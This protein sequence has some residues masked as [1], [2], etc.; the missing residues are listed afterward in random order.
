[1]VPELR[2]ILQRGVL[3]MQGERKHGLAATANTYFW[4][5]WL[6]AVHMHACDRVQRRSPGGQML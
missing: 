5:C 3:Q 4:L 2:G 6:Q 1:M